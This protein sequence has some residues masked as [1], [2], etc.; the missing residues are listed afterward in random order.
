MP[1]EFVLDAH[2]Y[3][4]A[5]NENT[6]AILDQ[7]PAPTN[8]SGGKAIHWSPVSVAKKEMGHEPQSVFK[9]L[10]EEALR[11]LRSLSA[12]VSWTVQNLMPL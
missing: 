2:Y 1:T 10:V 5:N 12:N 6:M 3:I 9:D 4:R 7:A 11:A 8:Q